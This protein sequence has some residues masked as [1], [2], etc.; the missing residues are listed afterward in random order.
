[1]DHEKRQV[2]ATPEPQGE[3]EVSRRLRSGRPSPGLEDK[4][5]QHEEVGGEHRQQRDRERDG[6]VPPEHLVNEPG[7][8][9]VEPEAQG[10]ADQEA[11]EAAG[12]AGLHGVP[13]PAGFESLQESA[14]VGRPRTRC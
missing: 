1:M 11:G 7:D 12:N 9:D 6:G 4:V 5:A 2:F 10:T 13:W 14:V 8:P 3:E